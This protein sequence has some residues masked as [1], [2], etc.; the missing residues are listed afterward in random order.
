MS[1]WDS[2]IM[3]GTVGLLAGS[4]I[5]KNVKHDPGYQTTDLIHNLTVPFKTTDVLITSTLKEI[6]VL[7]QQIGERKKQLPRI[8]EISQLKP[9]SDTNKPPKLIVQNRPEDVQINL[10]PQ[11]VVQPIKLQTEKIITSID[12]GKMEFKSLDF[13]NPWLDFLGQPAIDFSMAIHGLPG[14]GKSTFSILFAL[15]LTENFGKVI[16]ITAEEG[17]SKTMQDKLSQ[18]KA[19]H[20]NLHIADIRSLGDIYQEVQPN[21]YNFIIIDSLNKLHIEID[22]LREIRKRYVGSSLITISQSTKDGKIRG[23]LEVVHDC[24]IEIMVNKGIAV[25]QKNRNNATQKEL[26]IFHKNQEVAK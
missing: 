22:Q 5:E 26:R 10:E 9:L 11:K 16:Y 18:S 23:S 1:N 8:N 20:K 3:G 4:I 17:F 6:A 25:T 24:D 15:Y 2:I 13:K 14:Q 7:E 12:F 19:F 21:T